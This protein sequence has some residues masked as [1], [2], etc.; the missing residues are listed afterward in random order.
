[1][2]EKRNEGMALIY[3]LD[4][5]SH[6][7]LD[8]MQT[9]QRDWS[10][11]LVHFTSCAAMKKVRELINKDTSI[12][13]VAIHKQL[14]IAD[15]TSFDVFKMI[16]GQKA[17]RQSRRVPW[18]VCMS[19]CSL[20]GV[21]SHSE[22]FGRF[23][24]MFEKGAVYDL[25]GRPCAYVDKEICVEIGQMRKTGCENSVRRLDGFANTYCPASPSRPIG[26]KIQDFTVEREWRL[27]TE[28]PLSSLC[29]ILCPSSYF[30]KVTVVLDKT[31]IQCPVFP[32][33]MLYKWGV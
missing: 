18:C 23:G 24:L 29:G 26:K 22:R 8:A 30:N 20:P 31:G 4:E 14:G 13:P 1:M 32:L 2:Q 15:Q 11:Y 6:S 19:E 10:P 16:M 28:L 27:K 25:G 7:G 33:D 21:L 3:D 12:D 9:T 17:I 5:L